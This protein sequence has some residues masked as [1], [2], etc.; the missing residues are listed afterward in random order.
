[1]PLSWSATR[2]APELE[3]NQGC[4]PDTAE[5]AAPEPRGRG[6]KP[7]RE[8]GHVEKEG[9]GTHP[10]GPSCRTSQSLRP[11][12]SSVT[13]KGAAMLHRGSQTDP[14]VRAVSGNS[15]GSPG[16]CGRHARTPPGRPGLAAALCTALPHP[17][18]P[19]SEPPVLQSKV[20]GLSPAAL[21]LTRGSEG[22][23]G[24][25]RRTPVGNS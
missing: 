4:R 12:P 16:L 18:P 6:R 15:A 1:M 11:L 3:R 19:F 20:S 8:W 9:K 5:L 23:C 25:G 14:C 24:C 7:G 22:S 10:Q 21:G 17:S 2:G 13:P